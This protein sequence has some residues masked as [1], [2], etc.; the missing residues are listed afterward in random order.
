MN[1][2]IRYASVF[3]L[4]CMWVLIILLHYTITQAG[5][6]YSIATTVDYGTRK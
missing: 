2:F 4:K 3:T 5:P 1:A 6:L